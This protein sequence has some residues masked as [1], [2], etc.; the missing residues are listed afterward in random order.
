MKKI[1]SF[2]LSFFLI[3]AVVSCKPN[4]QT[5][6]PVVKELDTPTNV[7]VSDTGLITWDTVTNATKYIVTINETEHETSVN[8]YQ[9]TDLTKD[10]A[11][12]V[13]AKAEGYTDSPAS[14][15]AAFHAVITPKPPVSNIKVAIGGASE[16]KSGRQITLNATVT[17]TEN[18]EVTWSIKSGSE[19]AT[20]DENGVLTANEVE[21]DKV[22]EVVAT[23]K[24]DNKS[25]G[26]KIIVIIAKLQYSNTELQNLLNQISVEKVG[27]EGYINISLYEITDFDTLASTYTTVVKTSMDGTNWYAEYENGDIGAKQMLYY[28][29]HDN[30]ACQVGVNFLNEEEYFPMLNDQDEQ[31]SWAEAG[32]YNSIV[33]LKSEDFE[34]NEETWRYQYVGTDKSILNR[35]VAS[36]NPYDFKPLELELIIEEDEILGIYMKSDYDYNILHGYRAIQELYVAVNFGDTVTVPTINK[37]E[38]D[39]KYHPQLQTAINNMRNLNNYT[40]T[41][42]EISQSVYSSVPL[43]QGFTEYITE[44]DCF[45]NPFTVSYDVYGN[46][47][48]NYTENGAYGYKK[49]NDNLYNAYFQDEDGSYHASRAYEKDFKNAKPSLAFA[50]E[51]FR[52]YEKDEEEGTET[53]YVDSLMNPVASTFYYGVGNDIALYGIFASDQVY[54]VDQA[55]TPYVTIKDGYIIEA[56]FCFYLGYIYGVVEIQYSNFNETVLPED[57]DVS[58]DTRAVPTSWSEL[59]II[60][61]DD[62]STNLEEKEENALDYLTTYFG[63]ENIG[64]ELPFFGNVLGD[65]YGF[66]Y[67]TV[68]IPT[69]I[70]KAVKAIQFYYDVPLDTD[71][72]IESSLAAVEEYLLTLGFEKNEFDEFIKG[73]IVIL[74]TDHELDFMI[75]VWK[76]NS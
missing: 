17:G 1:V 19:F 52:V 34:F 13:V 35:I 10:F 36:A 60:V 11:C 28:K 61:S 39:P 24:D 2:I 5:E 56:G 45:F 7:A 46:E 9:V 53:Y 6:E 55:Y 18:Q 49:I 27:F 4:E 75:Y 65:S 48:I 16:V 8:Y 30:K 72:S 47:V 64:E 15:T 67:T 23:S 51:I 32:L 41:Y 63:N 44:T 57:Y 22:I 33:D 12:F 66:G 58:F 20:I 43:Y 59:T 71:Y 76:L 73:N 62:Q 3:I 38:H 68:Y 42:T 50:A 40:M 74:P 31:M 29:K 69:S 70:N 25:F 54:F 21:S 14:V 26:S 37:F